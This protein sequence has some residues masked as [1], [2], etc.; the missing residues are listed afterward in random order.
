MA[1]T[2]AISPGTLAND[3][4]VGTVA[5]TNTSN[6]AS[7]NNSNAETNLGVAVSTI[8]TYSESNQN[9]VF[10]RYTAVAFIGQ[11]FTNTS[12]SRLSKAKFYIRKIGSPTGNCKAHIYA[13][14]GTFG[15]TG[16]PTGSPLA[17]S[18]DV[19]V[20]TLPTSLTLTDFTFSGANRINLSASTKYCVVIQGAG[21]DSSN[22]IEIGYDST[23][24]S[25][26]GNGSFSNDSTGSAWNA[27]NTYDVCFVVEGEVYAVSNYLKATN[28]GFSIPAGST[29][30]GIKVD[31]EQA[32][33]TG[34]YGI[35]SAIR[36]VKADGSIGSTNKATSAVLPSTDT[37]V[38]YGG[39]SD[40]WGESWS[41]TDINDAD[42]GVVVSFQGTD[43]IMLVDHIRITVYYTLSSGGAF[44]QMF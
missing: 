29:I 18:D 19:D 20:S 28:F 8:D 7:S 38:T 16:K 27:D 26:S 23:S 30:N 42:F 5:W 9:A 31:I 41:S 24:P 43:G 21:A 15:T 11:S 10:A 25:H 33:D 39:A 17:T 32:L 36:I 14:T 12:F 13:H 22:C 2:G 35:E 40:L 6:A 37:Y 44:F 3:A 1:D 4:S 34:A